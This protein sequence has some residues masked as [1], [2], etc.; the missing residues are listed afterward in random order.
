LHSIEK[1]KHKKNGTL[2]K[3]RFIKIKLILD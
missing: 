2:K 3:C 1:V